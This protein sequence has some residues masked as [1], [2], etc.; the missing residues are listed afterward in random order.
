[1]G[2]EDLPRLPSLSGPHVCS[3][4]RTGRTTALCPQDP[5]TGRRAGGAEDRSD[6]GLTPKRVSTP[7]HLSSCEGHVQ[8]LTYQEATTCGHLAAE[9]QVGGQ[10][11][12]LLWFSAGEWGL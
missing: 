10:D 6:S 9:E 8:G 7:K 1:M 12:Q 11:S 5:E 2:M 3:R 4:C